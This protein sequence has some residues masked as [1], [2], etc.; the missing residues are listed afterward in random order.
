MCGAWCSLQWH[1]HIDVYCVFMGNHLWHVLSSDR[2]NLNISSSLWLSLCFQSC[3]NNTQ[4]CAS[5]L[6]SPK[7]CL[8][9]CAYVRVTPPSK[10]FFFLFITPSLF[11]YWFLFFSLFLP[12]YFCQAA[13]VMH[14]VTCLLPPFIP[15]SFL[16]K[17]LCLNTQQMLLKRG[18]PPSLKL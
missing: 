3:F 16:A 15:L 2:V 14:S 12:H 11:I 8:S 9:P 10:S 6:S 4:P 18:Y 13:S 7:S 5:P 17:I 1:K